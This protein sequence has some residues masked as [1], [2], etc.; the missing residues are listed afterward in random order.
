MT[1]HPY[2]DKATKMAADANVGTNAWEGRTVFYSV[3]LDPVKD[4]PVGGEVRIEYPTTA[5]SGANKCHV[6]FG[7]SGQVVC[8]SS[9]TGHVIITGFNKYDATQSPR[10]SVLLEL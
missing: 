9:P 2:A 8:D 4:V 6:Y 7:L 10:I 5:F 1:A 3:V